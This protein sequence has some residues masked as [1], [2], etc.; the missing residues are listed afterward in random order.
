MTT[1]DEEPEKLSPSKNKEAVIKDEEPVIEN[2]G[3]EVCDVCSS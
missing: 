3:E 2:N 1:K